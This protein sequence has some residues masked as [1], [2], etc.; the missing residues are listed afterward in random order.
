MSTP[1]GKMTVESYEGSDKTTISFGDEGNKVIYRHIGFKIGK[2]WIGCQWPETFIA[3]GT[4]QGKIPFSG[5][6]MAITDVS[7]IGAEDVR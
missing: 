6:L 4:I 2:Y 5:D 3:K 7:P 1:Q